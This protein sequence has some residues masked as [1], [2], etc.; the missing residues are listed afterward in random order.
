[1]SKVQQF[2]IRVAD[3]T[4]NDDVSVIKNPPQHNTSRQSALSSRPHPW[5]R[6]PL[7]DDEIEIIYERVRPEGAWY[8]IHWP[9]PTPSEYTHKK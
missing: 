8:V 6:H 7:S 5:G 9:P 3:L 1:M 2:K 4:C